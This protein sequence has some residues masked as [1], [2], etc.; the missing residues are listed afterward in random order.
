MN[1]ML[2]NLGLVKIP[3]VPLLPAMPK[4]K[5]HQS[6]DN[7]GLREMRSR[8]NKRNA[9]L[10]V[11]RRAEAIDYMQRHGV[12]Q[13]SEVREALKWSGTKT[14]EVLNLL[15]AEGLLRVTRRG[16]ATRWEYCG[17]DKVAS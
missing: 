15:M 9:E 6:Q 17:D 12:A 2:L 14:I 16:P 4:P 10:R 5:K 11:K 1:A 3:P 8:A 7:P 13:S